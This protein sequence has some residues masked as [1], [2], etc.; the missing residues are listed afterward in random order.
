MSKNNKNAR[1]L[2]RHETT[3]VLLT[4]INNHQLN[5]NIEEDKTSYTPLHLA[6]LLQRPD[7]IPALIKAGAKP[8]Y[9]DL[10]KQTPLDLVLNA[11]TPDGKTLLA[12]FISSKNPN[13]IDLNNLS[14]EIDIQV[15]LPKVLDA[16][17]EEN[18]F[19][20]LDLREI[21]INDQNASYLASYLISN[22]P[23]RSLEI[24]GC[25]MG[26]TNLKKI[27]YAL[28][29]NTNLTSLNM[30][31]NNIGDE[32]ASTVAHFLKNNHTLTSIRMGGNYIST[33][34]AEELLEALDSNNTLTALNFR[35]NYI[36]DDL[37]YS[38]AVKSS[39]RSDNGISTLD[40]VYLHNYLNLQVNT[41]ANLPASNISIQ[42]QIT[43]TNT[44]STSCYTQKDP[45]DF[46]SDVIGEG[47]DNI[48]FYDFT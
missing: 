15:L 3:E 12:F 45:E 27:M 48:P 21:K 14:L 24:G 35:F 4:L 39:L 10:N 22:P 30:G 37:R 26:S 9:W 31:G 16:L 25:E 6:V 44:T 5:L 2:I 19:T 11:H 47:G 23:L 29:H 40:L 17:K 32:G 36:E 13:M 41:N 20:S 34:G 8:Y 38:A 28:Q 18:N 46:N 42:N 33:K 7:I 1:E 43:N